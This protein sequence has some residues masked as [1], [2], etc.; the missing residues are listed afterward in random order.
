MSL[1][2][3]HKAL[4]ITVLLTGTLVFALFSVHLTRHNAFISE[5][6]YEVEPETE[7]E[8]EQRLLEELAYKLPQTNSALNEDQEFADMMKNFKSI[9]ENDFEKTTRAIEEAR[10]TENTDVLES[11][12]TNTSQGNYAINKEE[13]SSF[14]KVKDRLAMHTQDASKKKTNANS[15]MSY[16]LKGRTIQDYDTPRYLCEVSG[17]MV[18]NIT[19]NSQ[20]KVTDAYV[21]SSSTSTNEC[22]VEHALDYAKIVSFDSAS[23]PSQLGSITFY[24]KGKN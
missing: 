1:I 12:T 18:I 3:K 20:G 13:K 5:S 16:S 24:F 23:N 2:D 7:A 10:E 11:S 22:L 17:K 6:Y 9:N 19:V 14:Q 21:N 4:I 8:K 15:T